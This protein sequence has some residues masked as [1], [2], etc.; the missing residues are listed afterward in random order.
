[1]LYPEWKGR[2]MIADEAAAVA[3]LRDALKEKVA[4]K[5]AV[6]DVIRW[7]GG[8]RFTYCAIKCGNQM[9]A[10]SGTGLWY[11]TEQKTYEQIV[12]ILTR[13][14]VSDVAV[15]QGWATI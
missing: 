12:E 13:S 11:G 6:G 14:D 15:A 8:G 3:G 1:M 9:W 5:F 10:I 2:E 7:A 4:D